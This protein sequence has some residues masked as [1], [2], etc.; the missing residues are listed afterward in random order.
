M[1]VIPGFLCEFLESSFHEAKMSETLLSGVKV[2]VSEKKGFCRLKVDVAE[3][4]KQKE[5]KRPRFVY[6]YR[7][8]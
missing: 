3:V 6:Q 7:L 8:C 2:D 5:P 4:K 1:T